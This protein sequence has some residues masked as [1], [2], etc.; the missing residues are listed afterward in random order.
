[1]SEITGVIEQEGR[2]IPFVANDFHFRFLPDDYEDSKIPPEP[3][4]SNAEPYFILKPKDGFLHGHLYNGKQIF[5]RCDRPI[6]LWP[7]AALN[8][9][10]YIVARSAFYPVDTYDALSF[11]GKSLNSVFAQNSLQLHDYEEG[12]LNVNAADDGIDIDIE[13][14]GLDKLYFTSGYQ[15]CDNATEGLDI[16]NTGAV[17]DL[18]FSEPQHVTD[19]IQDLH[20]NVIT[21]L[22]FMTFRKN[23]GFES[24]RLLKYNDEHKLERIADCYMREN[25]KDIEVRNGLHCIRVNYVNPESIGNLYRIISNN[26]KSLYCVG[27]MPETN[28]DYK[29]ITKQQLRD[30]CTSIELEVSLSEIKPTKSGRLQQVINNVKTL[31]KGSHDDKMITDREYNYIMGNISHWNGPAAEMAKQLYDQN[32]SNLSHIQ[33]VYHVSDLS[34]NDIQRIIKTR[35]DLTHRG[36]LSVGVA[37]QED[38]DTLCILMGV[39]YSSVLRRCGCDDKTIQSVFECELLTSS[40]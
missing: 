22:Q 10:L 29:W 9:W 23:V 4:L 1:M 40:N 20:T 2:A 13:E 5:I 28:G 19:K 26:K 25:Y 30:V 32:K 14:D 34:E 8:T 24:G 37:S 12:K 35:N 15:W 36:N 31:V 18:I 39:V 16:H 27:F 38:I 33:N 7:T 11:S 6:G 17:L 21:M 3:G